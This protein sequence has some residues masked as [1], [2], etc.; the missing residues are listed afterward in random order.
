MVVKWRALTIRLGHKLAVSLI[1]SA[2]Y[3]GSSLKQATA[4]SKFNNHN[5]HPIRR[6]ITYAADKTQLN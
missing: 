3:W 1:P 6:C 5:H 4:A 2:K